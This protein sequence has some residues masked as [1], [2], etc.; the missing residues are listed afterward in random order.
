MHKQRKINV[1]SAVPPYT[2]NSTLLRN[3]TDDLENDEIWSTYE[4]VLSPGDG[5]CIMHFIYK[6]LNAHSHNELA[7]LTLFC[8]QSSAATTPNIA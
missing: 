1:T 3:V 7:R 8:M 6:C 4:I 5:H 2:D